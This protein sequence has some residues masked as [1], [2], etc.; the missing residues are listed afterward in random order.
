MRTIEPTTEGP[1]FTGKGLETGWHP[2][3]SASLERLELGVRVESAFSRE[4]GNIPA[5]NEMNIWL[6]A[7]YGRKR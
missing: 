3:H 6:T 4:N 2:F 1:F 5:I 7:Y